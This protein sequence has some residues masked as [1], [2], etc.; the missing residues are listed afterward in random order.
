MD[1]GKQ[2]GEG[3]AR[4]E[5]DFS[6]PASRKSQRPTDLRQAKTNLESGHCQG[7]GFEVVYDLMAYLFVRV[8]NAHRPIMGHRSR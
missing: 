2:R 4:E 8:G 7:L 1:K 6:C 3:Q 5:A